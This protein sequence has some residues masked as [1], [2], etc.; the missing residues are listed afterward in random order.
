MQE[1]RQSIGLMWIVQKNSPHFLV[2]TR[3]D[4]TPLAAPSVA[5]QERRMVGAT[6]FEPETQN[7]Q[8][9]SASATYEFSKNSSSENSSDEYC[10]LYEI[11]HR[12]P[13]LSGLCKAA[14]AAL[15]RGA[16]SFE[17]QE[18]NV[19]RAT[20]SKANAAK[21]QGGAQHKRAIPCSEAHNG[22]RGVEREEAPE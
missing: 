15:I 11:I 3:G 7:P 4:P 5:P 13:F 21:E 2:E 19:F 14:V 9:Y 17:D 20:P 18:K 8:P 16:T 22:E 10:I 6:G 12:W 1:R